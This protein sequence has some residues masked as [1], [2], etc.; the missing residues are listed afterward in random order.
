MNK[1]YLFLLLSLGTTIRVSAQ[2][3][4][5]Q[6]FT[7]DY[8]RSDPLL[9]QFSAFLSH[10]TKDPA[11]DKK[12]VQLRTDTSLYFFH[13]IYPAYNP[14]FF[15]PVRL[16]V[17]LAE[18]PVQYSDSLPV[19]DTILIYQLTA[20]AEPTEKGLKEV[21]KEFE[22]IHRQYGR[23]FFD[24]NYR[25]IQENGN[26]IGGTRNYFVPM[27]LVSPLT[28]TWGLISETNQPVLNIALRLKTI[29]NQPALPVPFNNP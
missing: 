21:K 11:I 27:H 25:D 7:H 29:N 16:E 24:S 5:L 17:S 6:Q 22:K 18:S 26:K 15:K 12:Q 4:G 9:G 28:I 1:L 2:A 8:F 19:G 20:Y 14:F 13:G 23:R 3:E 10:L